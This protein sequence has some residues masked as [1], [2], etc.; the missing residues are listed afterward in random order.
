MKIAL[1]PGNSRSESKASKEESGKKAHLRQTMAPKEDRVILLLDLD[2]FYAQCCCLR[3]GYPALETPL[4]LFQ[5]NSALAVTY[6]ARNYNIKRGDSWEVVETKSN[7]ACLGVHVPVLEPGQILVQESTP[8][9]DEEYSSLY[10]LTE[11]QQM[12]ARTAEL[13]VRK[14]QK[15]GKA[16]IE[17]FRIASYKILKTIH[18]RLPA[19]VIFERASIDEFFLDAT[20]ALDSITDVETAMEHTNVIGDSDDNEVDERL[21]KGCALACQIRQYVLETLGFTISAGISYNKTIAKLSASYGKPNGQAVCYP[22]NVEW[23]LNDTKISKCRHLGG[24]LGSSVEA[25]L[26]KNTEPTVGNIAKTLSLPL[27][28]QRLGM[29]TA[30]FVFDLTRGIDHEKVE[31]KTES[32]AT[33]S[34]TAFKSLTKPHRMAELGPWVT[35]LSQEIVSRVQR[36]YGRNR[37]YPKTVKLEYLLA[38]VGGNA[39]SMRLSFPSHRISAQQRVDRLVKDATHLLESK[40]SKHVSIQRIGL[41]AVDFEDNSQNQSIESFFQKQKS[42]KQRSSTSRD[43]TSSAASAAAPSPKT[44]S[45]RTQDDADLEYAR[46]L[47]ASFDR[48]DRV[49]QV[50]EKRKMPATKK[51][52]AAKGIDSFFGKKK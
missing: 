8:S 28:Q 13:G 2:S 29:D 10:C 6:P 39:K 38:N 9:L 25:L 23:L 37:R 45:K 7:G 35:L 21:Q 47:Q 17:M 49:L 31:S 52:K 48:Q 34:I 11:S 30:R 20:A 14:H 3:L 43:S 40:F 5:W 18:E 46:K 51:T 4:C 16:D 22:A 42:P 19:G 41:C 12:Q 24:K 1:V 44:A 36:D 27:L 26:P 15:N 32:N 50:L 33:K